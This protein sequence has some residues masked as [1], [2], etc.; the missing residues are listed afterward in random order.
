MIYL[1]IRRA[2]ITGAPG[3]GKTTLFLRV[4]RHLNSKGF[5]IGGIICPEVREEGRR[6]GFRIVD[7]ASGKEG[8]LAKKCDLLPNSVR[9]PPRVGRY[10]VNVTDAV[11]VGVEAITRAIHSSDII[12]I[13]EIGP[14]E[15]SVDKLREAIYKALNSPKPLIAV[16]H[17]SRAGE[18]LRKTSN[19]LLYTV[20]PSNRELLLY[21]VIK[22]LSH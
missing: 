19:S 15:L 12:G 1:S 2:L 10:C 17:R 9:H 7:L 3:V 4:I 18:I 14:M 5:S 8:F 6:I 22:Y 21:E 16:V 20:T 11:D 13:D